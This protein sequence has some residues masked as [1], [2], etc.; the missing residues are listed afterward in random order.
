MY[1]CIA[2]VEFTHMYLPTYLLSYKPI[3]IH[4]IEEGHPIRP[5]LPTPNTI[6]S[7]E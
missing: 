3:Y 1:I 4:P 5:S 2:L 7:D 6:Y